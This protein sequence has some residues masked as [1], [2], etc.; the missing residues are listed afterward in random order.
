MQVLSCQ[1]TRT[2]DWVQECFI[3]TVF[4]VVTSVF[5]NMQRSLSFA[6]LFEGLRLLLSFCYLRVI[7]RTLAFLLRFVAFESSYTSKFVS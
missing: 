4:G 6:E 2:I 7:L 5:S 3:T 1:E